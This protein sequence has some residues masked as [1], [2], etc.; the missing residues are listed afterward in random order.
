MN[1]RGAR[2]ARAGGWTPRA[3][4]AVAAFAIVVLSMGSPATA[5]QPVA[6]APR[7]G[8]TPGTIGKFLGGAALGLG[9][10]ES[11]HVLSSAAFGAGPGLKS[12]HFGPLPFFAITHHA[13]TSAREFTI[14]SAGFWTQHLGSELLLRR[15]PRLRAERAP[16]LKGV[17]AFN[18]LTSTGYAITA[19]ARAGPPERDTKGIARS[20]RVREPVIGA[21]VIAPALLDGWRYLRPQA[22]WA[23]WA[24]RA[25]KIADVV[26][27]VRAAR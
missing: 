6:A 25:V 3:G 22:R 19:F 1:A 15:R 4:P 27:V 10:H 16:L 7:G 23:R 26:L 5:Q 13:E 11:A 18:V 12:V 14:S 8:T 21:L 2:R 17:L 24:S 20:A 9:I